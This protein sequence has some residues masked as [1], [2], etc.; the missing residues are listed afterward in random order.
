MTQITQFLPDSNAN[1]QFEAT[2]DGAQYNCVCTFN[3]YGQ[4]YYLNVYDLFGVLIFSRPVIASPP[5]HNVSLSSGYFDTTIIFRESSQSF[6]IPGNPALP[7]PPRPAAPPAPAPAPGD[8]YWADVVLLLHGQG[9]N[10]G[11]AFTDSS[12]FDQNVIG[13]GAAETSSVEAK[14]GSTS[15]YLYGPGN[16]LDATASSLNLEGGDYTV[17]G[18]VFMQHDSNFTDLAIMYSSYLDQ[19]LGR[20]NIGVY[21]TEALVASEQDF[22]GFN[23][24]QVQTAPGALSFNTWHFIAE[25]KFGTTLYLFLDGVLVGTVASPVRS[26]WAGYARIGRHADGGFDDS[27]YGFIQELRVTR[28]V[29]RYTATFNPPTAPFPNF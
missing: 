10:G 7:F 13:Y 1:F 26:N 9:T 27:F 24:S 21:A 2:L 4:R 5:F 25:V 8:P 12:S 22:D 6:E 3:A 11:T 28:G 14:F 16:Y 17:E 15:I 23:L 29:A 18:W 19:S 20:T